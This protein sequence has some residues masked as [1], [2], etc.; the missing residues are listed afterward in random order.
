MDGQFYASFVGYLPV[1]DPKIVILVTLDRPVGESYGGQ[2]AAPIFKNIVE[3][4][5]PYLNILPSFSEIYIL[6]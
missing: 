4:I 3:R 2:T 6:Q 1:P 5:A